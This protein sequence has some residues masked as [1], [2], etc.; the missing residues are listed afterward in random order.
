MTRWVFPNQKSEELKGPDGV[1]QTILQILKERGIVTL[2]EIEDF[3]K[4]C[5]E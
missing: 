3:M 4:I 1:P 2:E 5:E